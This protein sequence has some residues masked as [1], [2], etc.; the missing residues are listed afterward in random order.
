MEVAKVEG[1]I[2][3]AL[4]TKDSGP[5]R[6]GLKAVLYKKEIPAPKIAG[7]AKTGDPAVND[8]LFSSDFGKPI[9]PSV[10][11]ATKPDDS[12]FD[13]YLNGT[14]GTPVPEEKRVA[15]L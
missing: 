8:D 3:T 13:P 1:K 12:S 4:A 5:P 2:V 7:S 14:K 10:K 9:Y 15:E 6:N 11:G